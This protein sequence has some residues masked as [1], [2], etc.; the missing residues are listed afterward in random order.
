MEKTGS[1]FVREPGLPEKGEGD[2]ATP[3]AVPEGGVHSEVATVPG[4]RGLTPSMYRNTEMDVLSSTG[5]S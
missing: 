1:S 5:E 4:Q 3:E 2:T